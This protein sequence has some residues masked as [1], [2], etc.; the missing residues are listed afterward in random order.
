MARWASSPVTWVAGAQGSSEQRRSG[1]L[2][3]N[4]PVQAPASPPAGVCRGCPQ[5]FLH[6]LGASPPPPYLPPSA[7]FPTAA[8][9]RKWRVW[10]DGR[11]SGEPRFK[12][13]ASS[14]APLAPKG[15]QGSG[16]TRSPKSCSLYLSLPFET[17]VLREAADWL[18]RL[19]WEEQEREGKTR[20]GRSD[21]QRCPGS[22]G[23]WDL[24]RAPLPAQ[25]GLRLDGC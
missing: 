21:V 12:G 25:A 19:Q 18:G 20:L 1:G 7:G 11:Y 9:C 14:Q 22:G 6:L 13:P 15:P 23:P 3:V 24:S 5:M 4:P 8:S 17:G 10:R 2:M 16:E